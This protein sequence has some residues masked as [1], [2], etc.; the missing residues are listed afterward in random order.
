M[1]IKGFEYFLTRP[2]NTDRALQSVK[3]HDQYLVID[4][5]EILYELFCDDNHYGRYDTY[6]KFK[7][8][9]RRDVH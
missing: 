8:I 1:G 9:L 7:C 3:L 5:S 2:R 4:G 6:M